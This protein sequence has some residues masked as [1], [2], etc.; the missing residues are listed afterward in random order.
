MT[1]AAKKPSWADALPAPGSMKPKAPPGPGRP[2]FGAEVMTGTTVRLTAAQH[3]KLKKLGG[4]EWV[5]QQI[6]EADVPK[7]K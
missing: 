6:D 7:K 5:R 2:C 4:G 3:K 1:R